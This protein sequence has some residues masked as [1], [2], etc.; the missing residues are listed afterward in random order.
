MNNIVLVAG[1][2]TG[3]THALVEEYA[4]AIL[5]SLPDHSD[6]LPP[7]RVLAVTF[8]EKAASEM[9]ARVLMRIDR[10]TAG[11]FAGTG[12]ARVAALRSSLAIAPIMTFHAFCART[13]RAHAFVAGID[14]SFTITDALAEQ[15][16]IADV[17]EATVLDALQ[18]DATHDLPAIAPY[19]HVGELVARLGL[20]G[21]GDRPALV[22]CLARVIS[23]L[24]ETGK[25][26]RAI[27]LADADVVSVIAAIARV[28]AARTALTAVV[29]EQ[30]SPKKNADDSKLRTR[31]SAIGLALDGVRA[32]Y[33]TTSDDPEVFQA[34]AFTALRAH[35]S[36]NWGGER[37]REQRR[38]L[39]ATVDALG[40]ACVD[41]ALA[42]LSSTARQLL[43]D[44]DARINRLKDLRGVLGF[45]DV[46]VRVRDMLRENP[47]LRARVS[48]RYD[49]ILV[50]EYQD[51]SPIQEEIIFLLSEAP[52]TAVRI[53]AHQRT[54]DSVV[55]HPGRVFVV[56]DPRQSIY[57]FRGAD[58]RVLVR[59]VDHL[60]AQGDQRFLTISRRST[61]SLVALANLVAEHTL[62]RGVDGVD[63]SLLAPLSSVRE[64][65]AHAGG[66]WCEPTVDPVA[67]GA[68]PSAP[69]APSAHEQEA[70]LVARGIAQLIATGT[71][72]I[73]VVV[74]VRRQRAAVA[75]AR[76][77]RGFGVGSDV[78][79]GDGFWER[80]E[81]SDVVCALTI[82]I[83][84]TDELSTLAV[85]R[86]GLVC[87]N[88]DA[89]LALYEQ[90]PDARHRLT[91]TAVVV[92]AK[93]DAIDAQLR[94]RVSAF[95]AVL[96]TV[97]RR[98][99]A[100]EAARAI[101]ALL[102][103]GHY[104]L[105]LAVEADADARARNVDKLR[106]M[107]DG[108][109]VEPVASI[110]RLL[111]LLDDKPAEALA[112]TR[113]SASD[114]VRI[115]TI[116]Q[117][118]GLEFP[119]VVL[120]D[121]A[122]GL[123]GESDDVAYD[124]DVGLAVTARGRPIAA[125][126]AKPALPRATFSAIQQVRR[127]LVQRSESELARLLY[128]AITRPRD[129]LYIVGEARRP[130]SLCGLLQLARAADATTFDALLPRIE[131]PAARTVQRRAI[132]DSAVTVATAPT[133]VATIMQVPV[134]PSRVRIDAAVLVQH[135][136][137]QAGLPLKQP[138]PSAATPGLGRVLVGIIAL[139]A[140]ECEDVVF[141]GDVEAVRVAL[142]AALRAQGGVAVATE[143]LERCCIT[144]LGP[145][146]ALLARGAQLA[147]DESVR[148]D[149]P[150]AVV[151]GRADVIARLPDRAI[152]IE[153]HASS[154]TDAR[155]D[156][157]LWAC[158]AALRD[159]APR[160]ETA[161]WVIGDAAPP[162]PSLLS[163]SQLRALDDRLAL[164][165]LR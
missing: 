3:K 33:T 123:R 9:R 141:A 100:G 39:V 42:G 43:I 113:D 143:A 107:V 129:A 89:L 57:G 52:G 37:V 132:D 56:G 103:D 53:G 120:A 63:A 79:G 137:A 21:F 93:D 105:A 164:L 163:R 25:T 110:T 124:H 83:D 147:F 48:Q 71:R 98:I 85:L 140:V 160:V 27:V 87:A 58:A 122:S 145:L 158:A 70:N 114:A 15:R 149:H 130:A 165:A 78:V 6:A 148:L 59:A 41:D 66:W 35:V 55:P 95:D 74:L 139:V 54:V 38:A 46:L 91:W 2:G 12:R 144:L 24:A 90:L 121:A 116:H 112:P 65:P 8:T 162:P 153:L 125:C 11:D 161:R 7:E 104:A 127:R 16:M 82:A 138:Q 119:V 13:L 97:R 50:D 60:A 45:S 117:A 67:A 1:A 84:P 115:M 106:S 108:R 10:D 30:T 94:A 22:E 96:H 20:R 69:S 64:G 36:G 5:G 154:V 156:V 135:T 29:A 86:S 142:D 49:R 76:A 34:H 99:F 102:D 151:Y 131:V 40:V 118:K 32:S 18:V 26:P 72:A 81:I 134:A 133:H 80:P 44:A 61:P 23:Q 73:D 68:S 155:A 47:S 101:D 19:A 111:E 31:L 14:P 17:I 136:S 109:G 77:L 75:I 150:T 51:T 146:R 159:Q 157:Q 92:A 152:V 126:I 62:A 28:A 88:D 4:N 128:V